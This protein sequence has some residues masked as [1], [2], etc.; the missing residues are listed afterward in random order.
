MLIHVSFL[1]NIIRMAYYVYITG[2]SLCWAEILHKAHAVSVP[3]CYSTEKGA[4]T[5]GRRSTA[6]RTQFAQEQVKFSAMDL[7]WRAKK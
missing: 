3:V 7:V 5:C 6:L 2:S 1:E 4:C